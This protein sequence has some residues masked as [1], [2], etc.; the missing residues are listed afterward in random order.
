MAESG[1]TRS[2]LFPME[3]LPDSHLRLSAPAGPVFEL[4]EFAV[5]SVVDRL[6]VEK[7]EEQL[8]DELGANWESLEA[9]YEISTDVLR[10]GDI[11]SALKD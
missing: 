10:F 2:V 6:E 3:G 11:R 4:A 7:R 9:L 8:L 1:Q 5:R